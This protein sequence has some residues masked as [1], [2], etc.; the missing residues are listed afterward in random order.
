VNDPGRTWGDLVVPEDTQHALRAI[1]RRARSHARATPGQGSAR[2]RR[3]QPIGPVLFVGPSG[4]GKTLATEII[5]AKAR[6]PIHEVD[7]GAAPA[8]QPIDVERVLAEA[9][10]AAQGN[11]AI[12]VIDGAAPLLRPRAPSTDGS[13][14]DSWTGTDD[15]LSHLLKRVSRVDGLVIVT[16]TMARA[17]DPVLAERF[18][19]VVEFPAPPLEARM[20]IWRRSLPADAELA[21]GTLRYL[22]SWLTWTGGTIHSCCV[23]AAREAASEGVPLQLR[24]VSR[25]LDQGYRTSARSYPRDVQAPTLRPSPEQP[26]QTPAARR[27]G[28]RRWPAIASATAIAA[29]LVGL[30]VA[31]AAGATSSGPRSVPARVG[32]VRVSLPS[33]WRREAGSGRAPFGLTGALTIVSPPPARGVLIIG[34]LAGN[35]SALPRAVLTAFSPQAA[36]AVIRLGPVDLYLYRTPS[37][38]GLPGGESI[39]AMPTT[40][41]TVIAI[42]RPK[43][44][45][46]TFMTNCGRVLATITLGSGRTLPVGVS[47]TYARALSAVIN[48]LN[49]VRSSAARQLGAAGT[50]QAQ[51]AAA[52]RLA[53]AHA[54]A[55]SSVTRLDAGPAATANAALA[56]ALL[57]TANGYR[58]L[59]LAASRR[60]LSAYRT[61]RAALSA[62]TRTQGSAF[63][64][65]RAFGYRLA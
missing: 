59:A 21:D 51:A 22:A 65:L 13:G 23:A 16:A 26:A 10:D 4:T 36:P 56:H 30:V 45:S 14:T 1:A 29:A 48:Q 64:Q 2:P 63:E 31:L 35:S 58:A 19:A 61:A 37:R 11:S 33:G 24:H 7:L 62:A 54:Q 42:C 8:G 6:L 39:Y 12:A 44:A 5:A 50:A 15:E 18:V 38:A 32:A 52:L 49:A 53:R 9:C 28:G 25:V 60:N 41:G 27:R 40:A 34:Q 55:A 43:D 57:V 17:I 20:E 3:R 46:P 47:G